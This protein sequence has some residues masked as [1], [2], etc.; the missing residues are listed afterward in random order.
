[1]AYTACLRACMAAYRKLR[2]PG[3]GEAEIGERG[4]RRK[5]DEDE[6]DAEEATAHGGTGEDTDRPRRS[7][8]RRRTAEGRKGGRASFGTGPSSRSL[9]SE[10]RPGEARRRIFATLVL[11][12]PPSTFR[13]SK[14]EPEMHNC[15]IRKIS[16]GRWQ[17]YENSILQHIV[18]HCISEKIFS[19]F[20]VY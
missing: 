7:N 18:I 11:A 2:G 15:S 20:D 3:D 16:N 4:G 13:A 19:I 12:R 8:L 6:E 10:P 5:L 14:S 1:M 9:L 17:F